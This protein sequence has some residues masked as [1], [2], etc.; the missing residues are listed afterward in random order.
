[1]NTYHVFYAVNWPD[2][3]FDKNRA[4][5]WPGDYEFVGV[6][7]AENREVLF[8]LLN[9]DD[10]PNAMSERSMC[11]GDLAIVARAGEGSDEACGQAW[12]VRSIGWEE[13]QVPITQ[14]AGGV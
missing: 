4:A 3:L 8:E 5:N 11:V 9:R 10:R 6:F 13:L 14:V 2:A 1:M 12:I 7:R